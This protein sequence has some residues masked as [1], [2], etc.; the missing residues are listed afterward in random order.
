VDGRVGGADDGDVSYAVMWM[1]LLVD[2]D[3]MSG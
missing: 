1:I 2:D 3:A